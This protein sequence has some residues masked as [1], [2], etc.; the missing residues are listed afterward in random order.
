RDDP[1]F[2]TR[3]S[4]DL[5]VLP[6]KTGMT[7]QRQAERTARQQLPDHRLE[8]QVL[9]FHPLLGIT[10]IPGQSW[11]KTLT[12]QQKSTA[13]LSGDRRIRSEEHTSELQSREN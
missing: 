13:I 5:L 9:G 2:P 7:I 4:S 10:G 8:G 1:A 3:R 6:A 11:R 12:S